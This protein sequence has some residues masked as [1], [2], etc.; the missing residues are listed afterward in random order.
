MLL[1]VGL[2]NPGAE[3]A[4]TRHNIGFM[5]IDE[6]INRYNFG[7]PS[8]KFN[9]K[10]SEGIIGGTKIYT[11]KPLT[12]MNESGISVQK[13]I[14][15]YKI[16]PENIIVIQDDIDLALGKVRIKFAGGNGGHNG[17]KSIDSHIG[18]NYKRLRI[19]IEHPGDKDKVH[20][21]VLSRFTTEEELQIKKV[22]KTISE[23]I[24]ILI[25]GNDEKFM[26]KVALI[27]K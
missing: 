3:Y 21:H 2:G 20:S 8:N 27:G 16:T 19:G 25:E 11:A 24:S 6:I 10:L 26:T 18:K 1:L 17:I 12:F 4:D 7:K 22:I 9:A 13:I 5:V 14:Q 15:F 23:N